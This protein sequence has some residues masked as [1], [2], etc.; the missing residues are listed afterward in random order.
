LRVIARVLLS[1]GIMTLSLAVVPLR[2]DAEAFKSVT[3]CAPGTRVADSSGATGTVIKITQGTMCEVKRDDT[4]ESHSY[5]FWMLHL[6]GGSA[7]TNDKLVPGKYECFTGLPIH[8][9]F[10][11]I[12][13]TGAN[14]YSSAGHGG[15]LRVLP[16]RKIVFLS[17]P[18]KRDYGKLLAGPTIGLNTDG[19]S[20]YGTTCSLKKR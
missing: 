5:L 9:T 10:M 8:Y 12:Y 18:L 17:G 7:E 13:V 19:G 2:A 4:G 16:S 11:D 15:T 14:T 3:Q 6:A 20:F 1:L